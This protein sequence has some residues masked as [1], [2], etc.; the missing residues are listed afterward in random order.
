MGVVPITSALSVS[1]RCHGSCSLNPKP[2]GEEE[3]EEREDKQE[4]EKDEARDCCMLKPVHHSS[5]C[6]M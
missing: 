5:G 2:R 3:E 1:R 4:E 6:L